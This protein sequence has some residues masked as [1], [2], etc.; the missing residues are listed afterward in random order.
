MSHA[1]Q[2]APKEVLLGDATLLRPTRLHNKEPSMKHLATLVC[3]ICLS[4]SAHAAAPTPESVDKLLV[5]A[6]AEKIL[7]AISPQIDG[8]MKS[9]MAQ[10][11]KGKTLSAGEQEVADRFRAKAATVINEELTMVKLKPMYVEIYTTNFTQEE[12]DGLISFYESPVGKAFVAKMPAVVQ[13]IMAEMPKRMRPMMQK[14]EQVGK[15][16]QE[17]LE[18]LKNKAK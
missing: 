3:A 12:I 1:A 8:M 11:G 15:E 9:I 14:M 7:D 13:A 5:L 10:A 18:A 16:M 6:H 4:I 2:Y 17:E